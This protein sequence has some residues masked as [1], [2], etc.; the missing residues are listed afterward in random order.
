ML[1]KV[2]YSFIF[3]FYK[4]TLFRILNT[5]YKYCVLFNFHIIFFAYN[6]ILVYCFMSFII[7]NLIPDNKINWDINYLFMMT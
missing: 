6:R 3:Y 7:T 4:N 2:F 5:N 1:C